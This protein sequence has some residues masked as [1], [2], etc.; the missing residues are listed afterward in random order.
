MKD[1]V[2]LEDEGGS[3]RKKEDEEDEDE[4]DGTRIDGVSRHRKPRT[5][6]RG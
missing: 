6:R 3:G 5:D 4:E 2:E 1:A